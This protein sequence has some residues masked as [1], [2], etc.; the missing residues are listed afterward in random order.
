[1]LK[2]LHLCPNHARR[3]RRY[4]RLSFSPGLNLLIGPNGA[5]KSTIL[6]A[7]AECSVCRKSEV[8]PTDYV[9]FDTETMNPRLSQGPAGNLTNMVLRSRAL[10][11]SHGEILRVA[12]QTLR[13]TAH[14]CLL[15]DEP[16]AGQD[17]DHVLALRAAM[18]RAVQRGAQ[19]ICSTHQVLFWHRAHFIEL[20]RDYRQRIQGALQRSLNTEERPNRP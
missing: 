17:F 4:R 8:G 11:S 1:M 14:T 7:I 13:I 10:F 20:R 18:D 15:L 5:G 9:L 3:V 16:E 12:F 6:Q 19:V 2:S